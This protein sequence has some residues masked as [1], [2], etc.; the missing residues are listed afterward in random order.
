MT[1]DLTARL[2][3][4]PAILPTST[5]PIN[6]VLTMDGR[7]T[8]P[9]VR[10]FPPSSAPKVKSVKRAVEQFLETGESGRHSSRAILLRYIV[11]YCEANNI[12]YQLTRAVFD[13]RAAGYHIKRLYDVKLGAEVLP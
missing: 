3:K 12:G 10:I 6:D 5:I 2:R 11:A 9:H 1:I 7:R 13:G 8:A 4:K